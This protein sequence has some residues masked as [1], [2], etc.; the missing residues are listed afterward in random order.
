MAFF[1]DQIGLYL[2]IFTYVALF[3]QVFTVYLARDDI[4]NKDSYLLYHKVYFYILTIMTI[5]CHI[6]CAI[7]DPGKIIHKNNPAVVEFYLNLHELGVKRAEKFNQ[8]YGDVFFKNMNEEEEN[9]AQDEEDEDISDYDE[10][11]YEPVTSIT[12]ETMERIS[13]EYKIEFKRCQQCYVVRPPRVHH[14]SI[15]KGCIM[16]MAHHCPWVN[17]CIGQFTQKFFIQFCAYSFTGCCETII[18]VLYYMVY[19]SHQIGGTWRMIVLICFQMFFA[20]IFII[21]T[22]CMLNEQWNIIQ[23][24]TTMIDIKKKKF[25]EKRDFNEVI[26]ET[27]GRGFDFSWFFPIKVGGFRPFFYKL[28]K[29]RRRN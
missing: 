26:N 1:K 8:T 11:H 23:N 21:F 3:I 29:G 7:T 22:V 13:K 2:F 25:L 14:C 17:N 4:D 10:T 6:K 15:C 12:D 27:F 9:K 5:W 28:L 19:K 24:D 16:K 20:I 18:I